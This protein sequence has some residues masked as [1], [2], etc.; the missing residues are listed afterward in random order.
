LEKSN[1]FSSIE[2]RLGKWGAASDTNNL[3]RLERLK[4]AMEEAKELVLF[5]ERMIVEESGESTL[6]TPHPPPSNA[7]EL[8]L[9]QMVYDLTKPESMDEKE[10]RAFWTGVLARGGN[11]YASMLKNIITT[12]QGVEGLKPGG[13]PAEKLKAIQFVQATDPG[14]FERA[15]KEAGINVKFKNVTPPR[16]N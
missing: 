5:F 12:W 8:S 6:S 14:L 7:T 15:M 10:F 11:L 4:I 2:Q 16:N 13:D 9:P 3:S 1:K